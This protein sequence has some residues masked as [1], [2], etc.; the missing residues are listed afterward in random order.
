MISDIYFARA[1]AYDLNRNAA[2]IQKIQN[3]VA[4]GKRVLKASDD[5]S[6]W[7]ELRSLQSQNTVLGAD[8]SAAAASLDRLNSVDSAIGQVAEDLQ[9]AISIAT[10]GANG[11]LSTADMQALGVSAAAILKQV[12]SAGNF[13]YNGSYVFAGQKTGTPAFDSAG[14][15]LGSAATNSQ[16]FSNGLTVQMSY[17]GDSVLGD[18]ALGT[19]AMG[20][21][22]NLT[23]S[24]NAG[25]KA[26]VQAALSRLQQAL[27]QVSQFRASLGGAEKLLQNIQSQADATR[28]QLQQNISD[29]SDAD[30]AQA[31]VLLSLEQDQQQA[32]VGIAGSLRNM[33]LVNVLA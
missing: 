20:A 31:A 11:T 4:T 29:L 1:L 22:S 27:A 16:T 15:Y 32:L 17:K 19:G 28:L 21:L 25:D 24:L 14:N 3:Q 10:E 18:A 6:I 23:A 7:G 2:E 13:Q 5:P 12:V 33:S 8:S 26:G 9:Q 30:L